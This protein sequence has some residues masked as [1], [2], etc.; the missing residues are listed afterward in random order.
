MNNETASFIP[1]TTLTK[2]ISY[3]KRMGLFTGLSIFL[4]ILAAAMWGGLY[5]YKNNLNERLASLIESLKQAN[6]VIDPDFL[7]GV[8]NLSQKIDTAKTILGKH[9]ILTPIFN[10]LQQSTLQNVRFTDFSFH[11]S[12]TGNPQI[13]LK[14]ASRDYTSLALQV[15]EFRKSEDIESVSAS[16]FTLGLDGRVNFS[17]VIVFKPSYLKFK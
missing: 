9:L 12:D 8:N 6:A 4:L 14:G 13:N 3:K 10:F 5:F 2:P 7:Y 16:D 1:K 11:S 17:L 15:E